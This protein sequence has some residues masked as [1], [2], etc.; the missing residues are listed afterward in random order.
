MIDLLRKLLLYFIER[1]G[2]SFGAPTINFQKNS[3]V[4]NGED[5]YVDNSIL[6]FITN[7]HA[8]YLPLPENA[9]GVVI[10]PDGKSVNM[11][12]G[13]HIVPQGYYKLKY[14]DKNAR[15]DLTPHIS[16]IT[17]DNRPI[18]VVVL[19]RYH[20][21][22]PVK[23]IQINYPVT[24][25]LEHVQVDT[26]QF[27]RSNYY[28]N[29]ISTFDT[30][31]K[32][33]FL[34]YIL[35][36]HQTRYTLK[37]AISIDGVEIKEVVEEKNTT[38]NDIKTPSRKQEQNFAKTAIQSP[39][40]PTP[41]KETAIEARPSSSNVFA[42]ASFM[43]ALLGTVVLGVGVNFITSNPDKSSWIGWFLMI[44]FVIIESVSFLLTRL[45]KDR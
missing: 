25:L 1:R 45:T 2:R 19:I 43:L 22:D 7:T 38:P 4:V 42:T 3:I 6:T 26:I 12:G 14:V 16:E 23:I 5:I 33:N 41:A 17:K 31:N 37:N 34:N 24:T 20:V 28:N 8:F 9:F 44:L 15:F 30:Q 36:Q 29:I 21:I 13:L 11:A 27:I 32:V 39:I 40:L 10:Y 18:N 35:Q